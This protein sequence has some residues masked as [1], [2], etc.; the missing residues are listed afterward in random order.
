MPIQAVVPDNHGAKQT[1]DS[2]VLFLKAEGF[3]KKLQAHKFKGKM[4]DLL[5]A[6][7]AMLWPVGLLALFWGVCV[8]M[9]IHLALSTII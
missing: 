4:I 3:S 5:Q 7:G 6:L 1:P 9:L 8:S 2:G